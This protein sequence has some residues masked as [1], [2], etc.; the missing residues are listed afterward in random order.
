MPAGRDMAI[1]IG[2][3]LGSNL[4]DRLASLVQS[5]DRL[6]AQPQ[7]RFLAQSAVYETA[8][9][10]V[11]PEYEHMTFLNAVLIIE[12]TWPVEPWLAKLAEIEKQ[13]GR[14]RTEDRYAPRTVDIDI[15]YAG[16]SC[17][18]SGGLSVPHPRWAT[19]RFVVEPLAEVR[20]D[21]V[22]PGAG[23]SVAAVRDGMPHDASCRVYAATW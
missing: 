4:G 3:G 8:P 22:L 23:R 14:E 15:L 21:M 18:D 5:R 19:R 6:I 12:S 2:F 11:R 16:T 10:G 17:I 13:L 1:E 9:V 7:A 20:P